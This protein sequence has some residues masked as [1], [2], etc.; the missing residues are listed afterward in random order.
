MWEWH[1]GFRIRT[2]RGTEKH[3]DLV[4]NTAWQ[5]HVAHKIAVLWPQISFVRKEKEKEMYKNTHSTGSDF[6]CYSAV[7]CCV[8][9]W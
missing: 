5:L 4:Y 8:V 2:A 7:L 1:C 3:F 6:Y 9:L